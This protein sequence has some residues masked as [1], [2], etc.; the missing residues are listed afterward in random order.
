MVPVFNKL[1]GLLNTH[2]YLLLSTFTIGKIMNFKQRFENTMLLFFFF[3]FSSWFMNFWILLRDLRFRL[4][5]V[6]K[7][8]FPSLL[9]LHTA[10]CSLSFKVCAELL[11]GG[12]W[13]TC[14]IW[15]T[16]K[17]WGIWT[18]WTHWVCHCYRQIQ[19]RKQGRSLRISA[20]GFLLFVSA[21]PSFHLL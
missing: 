15:V 8:L 14:S 1:K 21:P 10:P 16:R 7:L 6:W 3:S 4:C 17:A 18:E 5:W 13:V 11:F 9:G 12:V 19:V 2:V 20:L